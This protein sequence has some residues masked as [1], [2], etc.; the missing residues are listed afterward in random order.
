LHEPAQAAIAWGVLAFVLLVRWVPAR[1][2]LLGSSLSSFVQAACVIGVALL[3]LDYVLLFSLA[4]AIAVVWIWKH[5]Q[6]LPT[7]PRLAP[8]AVA[9]L[10]AVTLVAAFAWQ[11]LDAW[12]Q[13]A[14]WHNHPVYSRAH[15]GKGLL[16]TASTIR[17]TQLRT[18]RPVLLEGPAL[19]Q[20]P[21]VP[22]SGPAMNRILKSVYGEDLL[23]AKPKSWPRGGGLQREAARKLWESREPGEWRAL[24]D[25]FGFTQI[26]TYG[27][28]DLKLPVVARS[29]RLVLYEVPPAGSPAVLLDD[30][31]QQTSSTFPDIDE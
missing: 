4:L 21:Y 12:P 29:K 3:L 27:G 11:S 18:R 6:R 31:A 30:V 8:A 9:G 22:E 20:I 10:A 15:R 1:A 16:L 7:L 28:W 25:E 13:L 23:A 19:N 5:P 14:D 26:L 24:A 2:A 17:A